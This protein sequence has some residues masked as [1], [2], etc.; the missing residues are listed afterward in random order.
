[1]VNTVVTEVGIV[2]GTEEEIE[3][4]TEEETD[5]TVETRATHMM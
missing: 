1:M 5:M 4:E 2:I 3:T